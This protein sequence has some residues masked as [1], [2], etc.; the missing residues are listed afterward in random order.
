MFR[1]N[2]FALVDVEHVV[3][4]KQ[5]NLLFFFCVLIFN[6]QELPEHNHMRF[7]TFADAPAYALNLFEGQVFARLA[8]QHLIQQGIGLSCCIGNRRATGNPRLAPRNNAL[9]QL[10][11]DTICDFCVN[12]HNSLLLLIEGSKES[13]VEYPCSRWFVVVLMWAMSRTLW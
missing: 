8:Q 13:V 3:I 9:F 10:V 1:G 4:A 5:G 7:F 11:D 12:I 2:S 6:R